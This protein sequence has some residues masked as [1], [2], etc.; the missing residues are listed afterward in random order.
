MCPRSESYDH[1]EN[2]EE[3]RPQVNFAQ[4]ARAQEQ[5]QAGKESDSQV[6]P[7]GDGPIGYKRCAAD[8]CCECGKPINP[9]VGSVLQASGRETCSICW[10]RLRGLPPAKP[11]KPERVEWR[12]WLR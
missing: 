11:A 2:A 7:Q 9:E 5:A 4:F 8:L 1:E 3:K 10:R 12:R 6:G